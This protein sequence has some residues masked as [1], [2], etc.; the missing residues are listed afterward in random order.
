MKS[1]RT[2]EMPD[3]HVDPLVPAEASVVAAEHDAILARPVGANPVVGVAVR[4][5][6]RTE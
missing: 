3:G 1:A 4:G 6:L 2:R 5:Q